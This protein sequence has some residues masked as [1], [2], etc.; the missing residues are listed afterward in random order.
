VTISA[1]DQVSLAFVNFSAFAQ[2][3]WKAT[4]RLTLT[5][6]LRWEY[7]P[8]PSGRNSSGLYTVQGLEGPATLS[9]APRGTPLYQTTYNNFAPR[10]GAAFQASQRKGWET[11]LRGGFGIFHD[12]GTATAG[13]AAN[14]FP[15]ARRKTLSIAGGVPFPLDAASAVAPPFSLNPPVDQLLVFEPNLKLPRS[16]QWNFTLEQALG[17]SQTLSLSYVAAIGR[18]LL[19]QDQLRGATLAGNPIFTASSSVFVVRNTATSDYH[20]L[21]L[22]FQRRLSRGLQ[23]L[24]S[25]TWSKSLDI[26]SNDS[27][28]NIPG[29]RV[30][31]RQD[32]GPSDFDVRHILS[33]AATYNLPAPKLGAVGSVLRDWSAD[34]MITARSATP[35]NV[36]LSRDLGFGRFDVRPD[37]VSGVPLYLDDRG[38]AGGRRINNIPVPGN[39]SQVGPFLLPT[40]AR[41]G[42]LGRNALRGFPVF[43]T[44]LSLHREFRLT[45]RLRLQFRAEF[46]NVFNHPNF[47]DP[48]GSLGSASATTGLLVAPNA[49][50][51]QSTSLFGR[52]LGSGGVLGGFNPLYQIG[53]PRST[54]LALRFEF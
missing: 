30:D 49:S 17:S 47:A 23:A 7:N 12:L 11:V 44:D 38:V 41:Q 27:A 18:S 26:S 45:E 35:V 53:G 42:T 19:R 8:P 20:A 15:Y 13:N 9:L 39:P 51:G 4:P 36:T 24:A 50:F 3:T 28:S 1:S 32:R 22:K 34:A 40:A 6:G 14:F 33:A 52:S 5:Y 54:Q 10:I 16:Y 37:L 31:P 21:Q 48:Q 25:Y 43:Q 2:D 46:F 29:V